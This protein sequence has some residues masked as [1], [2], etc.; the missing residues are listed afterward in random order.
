MTEIIMKSVIDK[1][2]RYIIIQSVI[3]VCVCVWCVRER[4][5]ERE[6]EKRERRDERGEERERDQVSHR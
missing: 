2:E 4:E 3:D 5:R 6:R 1:R